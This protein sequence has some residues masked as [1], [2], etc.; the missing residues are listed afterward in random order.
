[1]AK[2]KSA[3]YQEGDWFGVPLGIG[4]YAV[5]LIA[6]MK[7]GRGS[8]SIFGYFFGPRREALPTV[9]ELKELSPD[10]AI[11]LCRFGDL[12]LHEGSWPVIGSQPDWDR[13]KWPMPPFVRIQ[14][15]S[16]IGYK[17]IYDDGNPEKMI[18][19]TKCDP[20]EAD[21][22]PGDGLS[23]AGAVEAVLTDKLKGTIQ[24]V[25]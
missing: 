2:K 20:S 9:E 16:G 12:G 6:R 21:T 13:S 19:E 3:A 8:K 18:S 7:K 23:G 5:G 24:I 11:F 10:D 22:H 17:V 4:G 25:S 1:M 14:L 15:I